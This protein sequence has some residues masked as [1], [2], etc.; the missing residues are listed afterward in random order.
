MKAEIEILFCI[1]WNNPSPD[2]V[3]R[4]TEHLLEWFER[5]SLLKESPIHWNIPS[6][7]FLEDSK[8]SASN[9]ISLIKKRTASRNDAI[10]PMGFSGANQPFLTLPELEKE[11]AW[12]V[13]NPW[14]SG[15]RDIFDAEPSTFIPAFP[16]T[17]RRIKPEVYSKNNIRKMGFA[18][19]PPLPDAKHLYEVFNSLDLFGFVP[20]TSFALGEIKGLCRKYPAKVPALL[21]FAFDL[22][23]QEESIMSFSLLDDLKSLIDFLAQK[24][25]IKLPSIDTIKGSLPALD[26]LRYPLGVN[27]CSNTPETR[28]IAHF[29]AA[30]REG[31]Q[32]GREL[33]R[34]VL[35]EAGLSV[36]K[37]GRERGERSKINFP[38]KE[39]V[40][41]ADMQGS[42]ILTG[43]SFDVHFSE[44]RL[45]NLSIGKK[46]ILCGIK[47]KSYMNVDDSD[48]PFQMM[49]SA[50]IE[51][52]RARGLRVIQSIGIPKEDGTGSCIQEF[53]FVDD[54]PYLLVT[55][56]TRYPYFTMHETIERI[57]PFEISLIEL[58]GQETV[59]MDVF[60]LGTKSSEV[61]DSSDRIA[62]C[63]GSFFCFTKNDTAVSLCLLGKNGIVTGT[64]ELSVKKEAKKGMNRSI[65]SINPF[66]TYSHTHS[67][68]WSGKSE[69]VTLCLGIVS[70]VPAGPPT[71]PPYV[72]AELP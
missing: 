72:L 14:G 71:F 27:R 23:S 69:L 42:A 22:A 2:T 59:S 3:F 63:T 28:N 19:E 56:L 12:S 61:F 40:S 47:S 57:A 30:A 50:S 33:Q 29:I 36:K 21:F 43:E 48:R 64:I 37:E 5:S 66:G 26:T 4:L 20:V 6:L 31:S 10:I 54:F 7:P 44:G 49:S 55:T 32:R 68:C 67:S 13:K 25:S 39:R 41:I 38:T 35:T 15:V 60:N 18:L 1:R 16:D 24:K 34:S 62:R 11:I 45:L 58:A 53:V 70:S 17:T 52:E 9:Y 8:T 51:S 46:Q 65:V